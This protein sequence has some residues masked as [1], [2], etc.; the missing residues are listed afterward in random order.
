MLRTTINTTLKVI[1]SASKILQ[2]KFKAKGKRGMDDGK[3]KKKEEIPLLR[4]SQNLK[5]EFVVMIITT[6]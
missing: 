3:T 5:R 6:P 2:L 1:R 4:R